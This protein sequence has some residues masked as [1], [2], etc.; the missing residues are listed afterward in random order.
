[1]RGKLPKR[2]QQ[3]LESLDNHLDMRARL[4]YRARTARQELRELGLSRLDLLR[5]ETS[6]IGEILHAD[7]KILGVACGHLDEGGSALLAVTTLRIIYVNQIPM[8]TKMDE[9]NYEAVTAVSSEI[10][11]SKATITLHTRMGDFTLHSV[12]IKAASKFV[13]SVEQVSIDTKKD[14]RGGGAKSKG[15]D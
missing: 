6:Y 3:W 12:N 8:F 9:I 1:M 7:E 10:G 4:D 13:D 15:Q 5:P 14:A 2:I 11:S